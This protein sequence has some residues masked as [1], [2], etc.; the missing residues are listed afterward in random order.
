[1]YHRLLFHFWCKHSENHRHRFGDIKLLEWEI[2]TAHFTHPF[3]F[4]F[5]LYTLHYISFRQLFISSDIFFVL[6]LR[7]SLAG[8]LNRRYILSCAL[9]MWYRYVMSDIIST[10]QLAQ[11]AFTHQIQM[12]KHSIIEEKTDR[13]STTTLQKRVNNDNLS[14]HRWTKT[15]M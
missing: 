2:A 14:H 9:A 1:M 5:L 15:S 7:S 11:P 12:S 10:H 3:F 8:F 4:F 6:W 13:P